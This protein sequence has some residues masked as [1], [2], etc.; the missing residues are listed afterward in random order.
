MHIT[1]G[2]GTPLAPM[3]NTLTADSDRLVVIFLPTNGRDKSWLPSL[4]LPTF[5]LHIPKS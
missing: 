2:Y 5:A 4:E 3:H 1:E